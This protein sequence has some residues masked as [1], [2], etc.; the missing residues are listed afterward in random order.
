MH[1]HDG[2]CLYALRAADVLEMNHR[3]AAVRIAF[4]ARL[5]AG[6]AADTAV[7]IDEEQQIIRSCTHS[8]RPRLSGLSSSSTAAA[9]ARRSRPRVTCAFLRKGGRKPPPGI[10]AFRLTC[11]ESASEL[12]HVFRAGVD[13]VLIVDYVPRA[14]PC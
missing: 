13:S 9:P 5:H 2:D 4:R 12:W 1:A 7:G 3:L 14:V 10:D 6:L 8:L 11:R